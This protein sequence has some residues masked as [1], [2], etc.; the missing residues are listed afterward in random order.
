M[1]Y[2]DPASL[3]PMMLAFMRGTGLLLLI[4]VFSGQTIPARVRI[5]LAGMLAILAGP[6]AGKAA[7]F[8]QHWLGVFLVMGHELLA[9]VLLGLGARLLFWAIE[10]AGQIISTEIGLIMSAN[11]DPIT[12]SNS[13][14]AGMVLFYF[15]SLLFLLTGAHHWCLLAFVRSFEIFPPHAVFDPTT[16]DVVIKESG[17]VFLLAVQLSAPMLAVN[18]LINLSFAVLG[19]AAPSIEAFSASM[20]VRI[21][22]GLSVFSLTLGLAAQQVLG[23]LRGIPE[24]MLHFLR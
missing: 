19:R 10:M 22:A 17:K 15:G 16:A 24:L 21:I 4:P 6:Y 3:Y 18:F 20:P 7:D 5:A 23:E 9:G 12:R 2:F 8:P 14:P 1:I 11:I 13:S